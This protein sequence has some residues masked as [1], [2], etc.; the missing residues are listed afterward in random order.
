MLLKIINGIR[1]LISGFFVVIYGLPLYPDFK[2]L[3]G[4]FQGVHVDCFVFPPISKNECIALIKDDALLNIFFHLLL[5]F[6]VLFLLWG[7]PWI[8]QK[9]KR[10]STAKRTM[11]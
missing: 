7:I 8:I 9:L 2:E 1:L 5:I 4:T 11:F 10:V 6:F 3:L